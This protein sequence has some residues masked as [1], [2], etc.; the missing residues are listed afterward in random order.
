VSAVKPVLLILMIAS[1]VQI[2]IRSGENLLMVP[3]MTDAFAHLVSALPLALTAPLLGALGAFFAGSATVSNLLFA[4]VHLAA[5]GG[6]VALASQTLGASYANM[7]SLQNI[8]AVQ[9]TVGSDGLERRIL[10]ITMI[11]AAILLVL[12]IVFGPL[13][14]SLA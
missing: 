10:A 14:V 12:L 6:L 1:A 5:G 11:P 7:L 4:P 3:S 8:V 13:L 2:M 9:A